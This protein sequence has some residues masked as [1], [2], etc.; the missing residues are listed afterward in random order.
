[1]TLKDAID[2]YISSSC[3]FCTLLDATIRLTEFDHC[4]LISFNNE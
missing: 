2:Y 1:M 4:R 3:V